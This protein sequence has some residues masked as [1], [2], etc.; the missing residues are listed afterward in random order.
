VLPADRPVAMS[1]SPER[2]AVIKGGPQLGAAKRTLDGT[3]TLPAPESC[4]RRRSRNE[5]P[6]AS[7]TVTQIRIRREERRRWFYIL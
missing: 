3:S 4:D 6:A 2:R 7:E 5:F 1:P